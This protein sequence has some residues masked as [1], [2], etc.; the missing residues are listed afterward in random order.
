MTVRIWPEPFNIGPI[1]PPSEA[2][3]LLLQITA[4][5]T[6][7]KCKFCNLYRGTSFKAFSVD[8]VKGTIDKMAE[9]RDMISAYKTSDDKWDMESLYKELRYIND[10]YK[11]SCAQQIAYWV[12]NGG[13]TV[14]LQDGNAMILSNGR[15]SDVLHHLKSRFPTI[16]RV[17]SYGRAKD[18]SRLSVEDLIQ[19]KESGLT[20]IHSGYESGDDQVLK[21]I[22]KGVTQEE[23][24]DA[25][26]KVK[27]AGIELSLYFMPGI[28]GRD[29]S[30]Q[31]AEGMA[32]VVRAVNPDFLRIRTTAVKE[33][34]ELHVAYTNGNFVLASDDAKVKE[35]RTIIDKAGNV[36]T[37]I[38]SD[39]IVN[40]LPD[41]EGNITED[42]SKLL[43]IIDGYLNL[44]D[45]DRKL[46]QYAR[47]M[48]M[49][50]SVSDLNI[51]E[52]STKA[53]IYEKIAKT[54]SDMAW[55]YKMNRMISRY[56]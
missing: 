51:L 45:K 48:N 2:E 50:L 44:S 16:E 26:K 18:L 56:I 35:I 42:K 22:N 31:N 17:T 32:K 30:T 3:S 5:C 21:L 13:K 8:E 40:L 27:A 38:K 19:L 23:E 6:W 9:Y 33:N 53:S 24:I 43:A 34:T 11:K 10:P 4:G 49:V 12:I 41:I 29:L 7:N 28:G 55:D 54:E 1:R 15:L 46:F 36:N 25:G 52:D 14:F 37:E 20:R 39:H 47:R